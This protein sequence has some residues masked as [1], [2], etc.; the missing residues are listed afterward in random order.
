MQRAR[1]KQQV[2]H[3]H[4]HDEEI[5]L[6]PCGA[7]VGILATEAVSDD[8]EAH[9]DE[10][11]GHKVEVDLVDSHTERRGGVEARRV[12]GEADRRGR[13]DKDD[14][15][16]EGAMVREFNASYAQRVRGPE[17]A[18]RVVGR[19][20]GLLASTELLRRLGGLLGLLC[21]GAD[22]LGR[23]AILVLSEGVQQDAYEEVHHEEPSDDHPRDEIRERLEAHDRHSRVRQVDPRAR[24][25]H[26]D[27]LHR[28][29]EVVKVVVGQLLEVLIGAHAPWARDGRIACLWVVDAAEELQ[30]QECQDD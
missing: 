7:Q 1:R 30:A 15:R 27:G 13:D 22:G 5:E 24:N 23:V 10:E 20:T 6:I 19:P 3:R 17:E 21:W 16:L 18:E 11:D 26:E 4:D 28:R 14:E 12:I 8:L 25:Q 2:D 29:G 9:L